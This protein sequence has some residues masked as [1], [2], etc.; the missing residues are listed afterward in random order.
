MSTQQTIPASDPTTEAH[1]TDYHATRCLASPLYAFLLS[2]AEHGLRLTHASRGRVIFPPPH[3][4]LPPQRRRRPYTAPSR[5]PLSTGPA[6]SQSRRGTCAAHG[7]QRRH[8]RQLR[9]QRAARRGGR[10]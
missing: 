5:P 3:R 1:I 4:G 9:Q 7:C 6:A 10:D 8:P 2:P